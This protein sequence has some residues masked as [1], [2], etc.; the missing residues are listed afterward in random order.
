MRLACEFCEIF[1]EDNMLSNTY[2][3]WMGDM[4]IHQEVIS[5]DLMRYMDDAVFLEMLED[6]LTQVHHTTNRALRGEFA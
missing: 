6:C 1:H 2:Y 4:A 5:E 3:F